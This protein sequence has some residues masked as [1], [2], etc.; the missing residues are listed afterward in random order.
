MEKAHDVFLFKTKKEK[1]SS[2]NLIERGTT[3]SQEARRGEKRLLFFIF[4]HC[5]SALA[6]DIVHRTNM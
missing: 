5:Y 6:S 4:K 1:S 2:K 3:Y